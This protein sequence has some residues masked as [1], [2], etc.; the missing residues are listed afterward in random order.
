MDVP[1]IEQLNVVLADVGAAVAFL[2]ALGVV[3]PTAAA[4]WE[5]HHRFMG[6]TMTEGARNG[7][8]GATLGLDFDSSAFAN[9][10]GGIPTAFVGAVVNVRVDGRAEVDRL[11]ELAMTLGARSLAAPYDAFWGSRL[12]VV[13]APGP[14]I[15]GLMTDPEDERRKVSPD[16]ASLD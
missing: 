15:V 5:A 4:G 3:L 6:P 8:Q 10:W 14:M 2:E 11:H 1:R 13:D 16:P 12:A 7:S 9:V